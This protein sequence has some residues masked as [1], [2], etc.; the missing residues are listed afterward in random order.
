MSPTITLTRATSFDAALLDNLWQFYELESSFWS[1]GDVDACGRFTSLSDF[2]GRLGDPD[3]FDWAYIIRQQNDVA[4]FLL[5]GR[6]NLH[7]RTIIEFAD[8]YVLPK[9]RGRGVATEVLRQTIFASSHPWLICIFREDHR[10]LEFW[11][12]A[13]RRLPFASVRE[14]V[15]PDVPELVQFVVN[16]E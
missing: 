16:D 6:Q 13:F 1:N 5:V 10:A 2:L 15:P 9:H 14:V 3:A 12:R 4:G 8:V 7:G 11:E